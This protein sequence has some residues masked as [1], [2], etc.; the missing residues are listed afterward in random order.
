[1][2]DYL[3]SCEHILYRKKKL[4]KPGCALKGPQ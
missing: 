3:V 2:L 1:M 4:M